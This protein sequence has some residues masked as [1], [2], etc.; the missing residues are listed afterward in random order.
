MAEETDPGML[1][2]SL[3]AELGRE[4]SGDRELFL[5]LLVDALESAAGERLKVERGGW[6]RRDGPV[7]RVRLDLDDYHFGLEVGRGGV[8]RPTRS[9][10]VRGIA[11]ST[12]E[13]AMEEW[14]QALGAALAEYARTHRAALEALKRRLW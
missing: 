1:G 9:R 13:L 7:R 5:S 3:A 2:A 12:E 8:L 14:L 11:L 10:V 4:Y 6:L